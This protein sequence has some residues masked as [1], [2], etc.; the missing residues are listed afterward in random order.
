M[1]NFKNL[2]LTE[3]PEKFRLTYWMNF[4]GAKR[5]KELHKDY[6]FNLTE[7]YPEYIPCK[8][9]SVINADLERTFPETEYF[10]DQ[11]N[12]KKLK[13][14]LIAYARRNHKIGYCQGFNFIVGKLLILF[15]NE[16]S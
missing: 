8:S 5:E 10:K 9:E 11:D 12:K 13:N 14:I 4:S 3:M 16:V 1:R 6:Y 7:N 2:L 15:N